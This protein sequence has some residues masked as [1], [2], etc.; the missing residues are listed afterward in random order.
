MAVKDFVFRQN[1]VGRKVTGMKKPFFAIFDPTWTHIFAPKCPNKELLKQH[2][3]QER[4]IL[5]YHQFRDLCDST[6]KT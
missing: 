5:Y 2:F 6:L 3:S 4:Q 1:W